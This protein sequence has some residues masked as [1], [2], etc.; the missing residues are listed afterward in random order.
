MVRERSRGPALEAIANALKR[1]AV[2][3]RPVPHPPK[4]FAP[5]PTG[6]WS[7][8]LAPRRVA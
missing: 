4:T 5:L 3:A 6:P 7:S 2:P 8:S 1:L